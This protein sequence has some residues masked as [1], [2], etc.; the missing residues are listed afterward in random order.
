M[1]PASRIYVARE[2]DSN[3]DLNGAA[4]FGHALVALGQVT[5]QHTASGASYID[6]QTGNVVGEWHCP[7]IH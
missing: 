1:A 7:D 4:L 6:I 2:I 3:G 5:R